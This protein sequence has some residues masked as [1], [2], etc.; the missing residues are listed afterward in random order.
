MPLFMLRQFIHFWGFKLGGIPIAT[1]FLLVGVFTAWMARTGCRKTVFFRCFSFFVAYSVLSGFFYIFHNVPLGAFL[2]DFVNFVLP[3]SFFF[4]GA[5]ER[6]TGWVFEKHYVASCLVCF[7]MGFYFYFSLSPW[8]VSHL[9]A[10]VVSTKEMWSNDDNLAYLL[11][12]TSFFGR[13]YAISYFGM[14][15][16]CW[17]FLALVFAKT[18]RGATWS[19]VSIV[20]SWIACILSQQR[21]AMAAAT[22]AFLCLLGAEAFYSRS[23]KFL[24]KFAVGIVLFA[25]AIAIFQLVFPERFDHIKSRIG[26]RTETLASGQAMEE[27]V[28][29]YVE[30]MGRWNSVIVGYGLGSASAYAYTHGCGGVP[31]G[32]YVKIL[33]EQGL[34]GASWFLLLLISTLYRGIRYFRHYRFEVCLILCFC[35]AAIGSSAFCNGNGVFAVSLWYAVGRIWNLRELQARQLLLQNA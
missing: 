8:Y 21:A 12:F 15:T 22:A 30:T 2:Y 32:N 33:Y 3:M 18:R 35:L 11:R 29:Q 25:L 5:D 17:S 10:M 27:R 20:A 31:D 14:S 23:M 1:P 13:S 19:I 9:K 6:G 28:N 16:L 26:G 24:A 4:I 7:G 34:V